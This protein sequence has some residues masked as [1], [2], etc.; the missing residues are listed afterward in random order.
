MKGG[1]DT[2]LGN[3]EKIPSLFWRAPVRH[4]DASAL[5]DSS[6]STACRI[7]SS[8]RLDLAVFRATSE[9]SPHLAFFARLEA[10]D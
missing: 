3:L 8:T 7:C 10:R 4:T 9:R 6:P 2:L 5:D 1:T